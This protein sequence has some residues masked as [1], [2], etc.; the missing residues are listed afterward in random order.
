M[1]LTSAHLREMADRL[2]AEEAEAQRELADAE[3]AEERTAIRAEIDELKRRN[4]ELEQRIAAGASSSNS[5]DAD[6]GDEEEGDEEEGDDELDQARTRRRTRAGRKRGQV[7]QDSPGEP[8]YVY[9]GDDEPDR[10]PLD[11]EPDE[12]ETA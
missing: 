3:T 1:P 12:E 10:V 2:D 4:A 7:Y 11:E 9:Q 6:E 5:S 8:G